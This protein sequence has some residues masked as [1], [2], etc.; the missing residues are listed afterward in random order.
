MS[1][2]N[3]NPNTI[4]GGTWEQIQDRFLLAAGS[5]Y[6]AGNTGGSVNH[7]HTTNAG[8]TGGTAITVDQMPSHY[9]IFQ[10][11]QWYSADS[12]MNSA[13]GSIYSWKSGTGGTTSAGYKGSASNYGPTGGGQAHTHPQVS[14]DT[15]SQS[16][17]PPYLVVYIWKRTA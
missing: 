10:R 1:V 12:V 7:S 17:M 14:V 5:T 4:I 8:T 2:N 15:N 11:Q 6:T 9:H 3:I 13:T 16:N